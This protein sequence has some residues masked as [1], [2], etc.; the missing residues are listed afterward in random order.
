MIDEKVLPIG[1][2]DDYS[3]SRANDPRKLFEGA[4]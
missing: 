2:E 4:R 3:A 1:I